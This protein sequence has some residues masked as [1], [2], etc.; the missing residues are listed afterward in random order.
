MLDNLSARQGIEQ[1]DMDV[2][3]I[4]KVWISLLIIDCLSLLVYFICRQEIMQQLP[5]VTFQ[6]ASAMS[7]GASAP[8]AFGAP[9]V[10]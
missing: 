4:S 3:A 9:Q 1:L 10:K 2:M 8:L 5:P 6:S 7:I